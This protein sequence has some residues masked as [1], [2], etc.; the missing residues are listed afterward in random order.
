M[1]DKDMFRLMKYYM[2]E[3]E[4]THPELDDFFDLEE[5]IKCFKKLR[6]NSADYPEEERAMHLFYRDEVLE[7]MQQQIKT[8]KEID[9]EQ[10]E[11]L[12][13]EAEL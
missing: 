12:E 5:A 2:D 6:L 9:E 10:D 11:N 7:L 13:E 8:H 4:K 1:I 3:V